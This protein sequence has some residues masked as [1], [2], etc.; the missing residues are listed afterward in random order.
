MKIKKLLSVTVIALSLVLAL[1]L[2]VHAAATTQN[3]LGAA[4]DHDPVTVYISLQKG[5]D[6]SYQNHV[7]TAFSDWSN[8]L[9]TA[10]EPEGFDFIF[11]TE[12]PSKKNPADITV[13][14]RK[15]TGIVLG[16]AMVSSSGGTI[17][18]VKITLAA[19]NAMGLPLQESDFRTIAR[20]EIGHALGLGHSNDDGQEP[21]DLMS[22]SFDFVGVNYDIYPSE[23]NISATLSIYGN[24]GFGTPN[25]SPIP[26]SYP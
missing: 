17:K 12:K 21:L 6:T 24:D 14:V 1:P 9:K 11:L 20:H 2:Q 7:E 22:P 10:S 5:V 23:L 18:S 13:T 25:T 19:Y 16:S 4:W 15:N 26:P 8:A 3:L